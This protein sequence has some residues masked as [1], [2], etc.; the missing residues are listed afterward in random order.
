[1]E[2][3][4]CICLAMFVSKT[5]EHCCVA[6]EY[7]RSAGSTTTPN[8]INNV[9]WVVFVFAYVTLHSRIVCEV[10]S[11]AELKW[12]QIRQMLWALQILGPCHSSTIRI[13]NGSLYLI[14]RAHCFHVL[15]IFSEPQNYIRIRSHK[16]LLAR[17]WFCMSLY[18]SYYHTR[19]KK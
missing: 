2:A 13:S 19:E 11:S 14:E 1:M 4:I 12:K 7:F 16:T 10:C 8:T 5:S 6:Y 18:F 15:E 17:H 9:Y 3:S